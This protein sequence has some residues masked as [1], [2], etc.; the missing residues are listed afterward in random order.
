MKHISQIKNAIGI[1]AVYA[2]V[3]ARR[4][5]PKIKTDRGAQIDLLIDRNDS[6]INICEI[7]FSAGAFEISKA[8]SKELE[9]KLTVFKEQT[10]TR[11][12]L[13]LTMITTLGVKNSANYPGLVQI[14]VSMNSLFDVQ[15][16]AS[17]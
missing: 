17:M 15:Y 7:K 14:E 11:K 9:N 5:Q 16:D 1:E 4:H 10:K 8:Y 3:S 13:F 2:E 12:T 6:F